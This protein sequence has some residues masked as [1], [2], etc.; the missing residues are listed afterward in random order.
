MT[1]PQKAGSQTAGPLWQPSA[2]RIAAANLTAF[3]RRL[4]E[5]RGLAFRDYDDLYAWSIHDLEG[6]WTAVWDFCGV[7]ADPEGSPERGPVVVD[8][9]KMPGARFFPEAKLNFAENLLRRRDHSDAL[10]FWG[11]DKVKRRLSHRDVYDRVSRLAQAL[12]AEGVGPGDRVAGFMPNMPEAVIAM[13]AATSLGAVWSSCSPDFGVQGVLDR[14]GQIEPKVLFCPDGYFYNGKTIDSRPRVAAFTAELPSL[15]KI[16][17]VPYVEAAPDV[18]GI[19]KAV[20]LDDFVAPYQAGAIA[21]TRMPFNAPLYI[22]FSSGTTGKPKC[23]VHGIGGTLLQHLKEHILLCDVKRGDRVFYFTTCGWMMWNWLVSALAAEATLL[24]YDGSPFAPDGNILFDYADAEKMTLFGTSAKYID[25][26]NKAGLDPKSTHDLSSLRLLTSTGSPLVPEGFDY[27]YDHIK[28][29]ICLSSI[30]GGTDIISCFVGGNPIGPVWRGEIQR[31]CLGMAV[32]VYDD[33][34]KPV[35]GEKGELV[36]VKPFPCMPIGFWND[37]D[38]QRYRAAYFETYPNIW[39]HGDFVEL[40]EHDGIIVYGRSDATLNPGGVRI[41]T[42]EIYRQVEKLQEV[43]ESIVIGQDWDGDV[44][45]VLFVKLRPGIALDDDLTQRIKTQI[46]T[47]C[48]PRH[49]P[50]KVVQV[51]DIP[52]TKSGKIVELA[53]RDVVH[54][55]P[56]KNKEALANP[57]A[58]DLYAGLPELSA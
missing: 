7:I 1:G 30:A 49:V 37:P 14:F 18:S 22:M 44:R 33:N 38:G 41:G 20:R 36:C 28:Q 15:T 55:R 56:V 46:R 40:T 47:G 12:A 53:V 19:A 25:A 6:F 4:Q 45:V 5:T 57:E 10:V 52:R 42:A 24:L 43:E 26:L 27:V 31:R 11:E 3:M 17:V 58:L 34:G 35:R 32:E 39:H 21:F 2:A 9:D 16:V 51:A 29:D 8:A 48:T 50:A 23:I 54:G 13:L